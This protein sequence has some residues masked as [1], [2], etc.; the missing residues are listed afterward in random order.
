MAFT[1]IGF[2]QTCSSWILPRWC[3]RTSVIPSIRSSPKVVFFLTSFLGIL[4]HS[5]QIGRDSPQIFLFVRGQ[6][7]FDVFRV[8]AEQ[9]NTRTDHK[10]QIND[11]CA[12]A[13]PFAFRRP[14][15]LPRA[16]GAWDHVSTV[17]MV[18]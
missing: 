17:R 16:A 6:V 18:D 4:L 13:L 1:S 15:Q 11:P 9:V 3:A 8:T 7:R 12:A 2:G 10:V 5:F 14:P